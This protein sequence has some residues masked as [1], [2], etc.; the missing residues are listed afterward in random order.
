M[1]GEKSMSE[2]FTKNDLKTLKKV[3]NYWIPEFSEYPEKQN[4]QKILQ[5]IDFALKDKSSCVW[6]FCWD[7]EYGSVEGLFV[8]N[9]EDIEQ[10]IGKEIYFGDILGKHSCVDGI[11]EYGDIKLVSDDP[12]IVD[13]VLTY[14]L[15]FGYNPLHYIVERG[16]MS[17][18]NPM[19][20]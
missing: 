1:N 17:N 16:V 19:S 7:S 8:A 18:S 15:V 12:I 13:T 6:K 4:V 3:L 2:L 14:D 5:K 10:S 20:R 9:R 11:L